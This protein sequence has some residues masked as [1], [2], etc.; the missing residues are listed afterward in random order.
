M[1]YRAILSDTKSKPDPTNYLQLDY[2][3]HLKA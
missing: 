1:E 2:S 3:A